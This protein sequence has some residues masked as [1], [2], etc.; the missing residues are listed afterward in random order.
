[1]AS[2]DVKS[3]DI[4]GNPILLKDVPVLRKGKTKMYDVDELIRAELK[5]NAKK[6]V[7]QQERIAELEKE[8]QRLR[9]IITDWFTE[10]KSGNSS[11]PKDIL[12]RILKEV[13]NVKDD[14]EILVSINPDKEDEIRK[15]LI[16]A[17]KNNPDEYLQEAWDDDVSEFM[18]DSNPLRIAFMILHTDQM[19]REAGLGDYVWKWFKAKRDAERKEAEKDD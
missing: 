11:I 8:N 6:V 4:L 7:E 13:E 2:E 12:D 5:A 1:M 14:D 15:Y 9:K 17:I 10:W 18:E 3:R 16:E 19:Y